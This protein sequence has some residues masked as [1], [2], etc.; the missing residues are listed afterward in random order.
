[1]SPPRLLLITHAFPPLRSARSLQIGKLVKYALRAGASFEVI[2]S[3]IG[4]KFSNAEG[5]DD[6]WL[7]TSGQL[8]VHRCGPSGRTVGDKLIS[9]ATGLPHY[10]WH[11]A[12]LRGGLEVIQSRGAN[13]FDAMV[14]FFSPAESHIVAHAIKKRYPSLPW[15]AHFADPLSA[16][17]FR[18][19]RLF[20]RETV[21]RRIERRTVSLA[22][23]LLFVGEQLL[24]FVMARYPRFSGKAQTLF[25]CFDPE[26]YPP[27]EQ[28]PAEDPR[29]LTLAYVGGFTALRNFQ[30]LL[31]IVSRLRASGE[32]LSRIRIEL[33]GGQTGQAAAALNA[34]RAGLAHSWGNVDYRQSL[35]RMRAADGLILID[36]NTPQSPFYPSKLVDYFGSLRPILGI[37]PSHSYST[38]L[39]RRHGMPVFDYDHLDHCAQQVARW[40]ISARKPS[41]YAPEEV[42]CYDAYAVARR[43]LQIVSVVSQEARQT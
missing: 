7:T 14:S 15:L 28:R 41:P 27:L 36:A 24:S 29:P 42:A 34:V 4:T 20:W 6:S 10:R 13:Y 9:V 16:N 1:M 22:D 26:L 23:G 31:D 2:A 40:M 8:T 12:A 33:V 21:R 38:Q 32:D 43:F 3:Q 39:L 30:P 17:P 37:S 35:L 19:D 18:D 5:I 25:H 11:R